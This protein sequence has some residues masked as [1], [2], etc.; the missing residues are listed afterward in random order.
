MVAQTSVV[1]FDRIQSFIDPW[2]ATA[3][4]RGWRTYIAEGPVNPDMVEGCDIIFCNWAD[5]LA[6]S[7]SQKR[8]PGHLAVMVRSYEAYSGFLSGMNWDNVDLLVFVAPH[9]NEYCR[10]TY[11]IP[12]DLPTHIVPDCVDPNAFPLKEDLSKGNRVAYVGRFGAPKNTEFLVSAAYEYP[13]YEFC[14]KGPFEDKRCQAFMAYHQA[15]TDNITVEGPSG[16]G[17]WHDGTGVNEFLDG[18]H[19]I[20]SPSYHEGT[21]MALL[22]GMSK[23]LVPLVQ[24]RPGALYPWTYSS[25]KDFGEHLESQNPSEDFRK[26]IQEYRNTSIREEAINHMWD[27]LDPSPAIIGK[28]PVYSIDGDL[29]A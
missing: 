6:V 17:K 2:V 20:A 24:D 14:F 22:E 4:G 28:V 29:G 27:A 11:P 25:M 9:I 19:Y 23:G 18:C 1:I 16:S 15:R 26:F 13:D 5:H 12:E 7:L 21:H 3:Q 10:I 8:W